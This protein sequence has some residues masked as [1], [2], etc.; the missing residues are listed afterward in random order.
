MTWLE[1][2]VLGF[3]SLAVIC[4]AR[5]IYRLQRGS[6]ADQVLRR[7]EAREQAAARRPYLRFIV[8]RIK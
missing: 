7:N 6:V 1:Y 4:I 2:S 3:L 8:R 5:D